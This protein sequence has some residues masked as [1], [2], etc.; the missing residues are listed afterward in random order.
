MAP[1]HRRD[2]GAWLQALGGDPRFFFRR[3]TPAALAPR[4]HLDPA[5]SIVPNRAL[6]TVLM[7][8]L[9]TIDIP[10]RTVLMIM[11]NVQGQALSPRSQRS[12]DLTLTFDRWGA[13][14]SYDEG[15]IGLS[16]TLLNSLAIERGRDS[17]P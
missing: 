2:V 5:Q 13:D 3:P 11:L 16:P 4:N 8:V 12:S 9:M 15:R 14:A 7:M 17:A 1:R 6:R 10:L